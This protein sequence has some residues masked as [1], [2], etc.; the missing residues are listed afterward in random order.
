MPQLKSYVENIYKTHSLPLGK[1][2]D[3]FTDNL[4]KYNIDYL[5][6][7]EKI[8]KY[9]V[10]CEQ[11]DKYIETGVTEEE[12]TSYKMFGEDQYKSHLIKS[13]NQKKVDSAML[14]NCLGELKK[15]M[16]TQYHRNQIP[17]PKCNDLSKYP[18]ENL[19]IY[20]TKQLETI[21][22][23]YGDLPTCNNM[24]KEGFIDNIQDI[25]EYVIKV[26]ST[27]YGCL[28]NISDYLNL[29]F[30][31]H[32]I[33]QKYLDFNNRILLRELESKK[34]E[35]ILDIVKKI[36]PCLELT[37]EGKTEFDRRIASYLAEYDQNY[38]GEGILKFNTHRPEIKY[39]LNKFSNEKTQYPY[40]PV[41]SEEPDTPLDF[42]KI[43]DEGTKLNDFFKDSD[44]FPKCP[45]PVP[46]DKSKRPIQNLE[47]CLSNYISQHDSEGTTS[48]FSP[49]VEIDTNALN[50]NGNIK[51]KDIKVQFPKNTGKINKQ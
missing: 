8:Y 10:N 24:D 17:T 40:H 4:L 38:Q 50:K 28:A 33:D 32:Q 44:L 13:I 11:L 31:E 30:K 12:S 5:E 43:V 15:Y 35:E 16:K 29:K 42:Q 21:N 39:D 34:L 2:Q 25:Y 45:K 22:Q 18:V 14:K 41:Y 26:N 7:I 20:S 23:L 9:V 3:V 46:Y 6:F 51:A 36:P 1:N 27:T 49:S 37:K 19:N 47:K 48:I